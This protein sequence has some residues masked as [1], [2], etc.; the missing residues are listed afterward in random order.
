M[1]VIIKGYSI[2]HLLNVALQLLDF[3]DSFE[4]SS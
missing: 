2:P 4:K 3:H 1:L